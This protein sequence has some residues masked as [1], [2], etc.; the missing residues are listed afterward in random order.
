[1]VLL[2]VRHSPV[3]SDSASPYTTL[4]RSPSTRLR[5]SAS[6]ARGAGCCG[7]R[8][9]HRTSCRP[10]CRRCASGSAW[11]TRVHAEPL[12]HH[13]QGGLQDRKS[14]RLDS[15]HVKISYAVCCLKKN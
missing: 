4:C 15:S 8:V 12:A 7:N 6:P 10:P 14:T 3:A 9:S 2:L 1:P 13:L 5:S 11:T